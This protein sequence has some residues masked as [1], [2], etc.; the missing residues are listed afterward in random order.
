[1]SCVAIFLAWYSLFTNL[2]KEKLWY[3]L[4]GFFSIFILITP[5]IVEFS[6]IL[7]QFLYGSIVDYF[8]EAWK[9]F[10]VE[11]EAS[12]VPVEVPFEWVW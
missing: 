2:V 12:N 3:W 4:L 8:L 11:V 10:T 7:V 6:V 1:M 5:P 9:D